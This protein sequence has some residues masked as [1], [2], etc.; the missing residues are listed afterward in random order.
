MKNQIR[1]GTVLWFSPEKNTGYIRVSGEPRDLWF[2]LDTQRIITDGVNE[3]QF[4][5]DA[6]KTS[7]MPSTG[8]QVA[9]VLRERYDL[10]VSDERRTLRRVVE[11][12]GW[13]FLFAYKDS[14]RRIANRPVCRVIIHT[15]VEGVHTHS[16]VMPD[17]RGTAE[18]LQA[19]SPRGSKDD[20]FAPEFVS[21]EL[22]DRRQFQKLDCGRWKFCTDPRPAPAAKSE[23]KFVEAAPKNE[24]LACPLF[25][26]PNE[27]ETNF[28]FRLAK[29]KARHGEAVAA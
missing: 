20:L 23:Q 9:V 4:V 2:S 27:S 21:G 25:Q 15:T 19:Q 17:A 1:F 22:H 5:K 11:T 6:P 14:V 12:T 16:T 29:W 3:P 28:G 18:E 26:F 8:S 7:P 10:T 13:N 24:A